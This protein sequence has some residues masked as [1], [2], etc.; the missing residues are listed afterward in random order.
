[1]PNGKN[2][3]AHIIPKQVYSSSNIPTRQAGHAPI[4]ITSGGTITVVLVPYVGTYALFKGAVGW[5]W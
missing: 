4:I 2:S 5:N 1:M 3:I